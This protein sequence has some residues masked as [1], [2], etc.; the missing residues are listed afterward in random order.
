MLMVDDHP[1][2]LAGLTALVSSDPQLEIV[3]EA[4]DGRSA[5]E[6][7]RR[8]R[9]DIVV[10][11]ISIPE[12]T[13][14]TVMTAL[15]AELPATRVLVLTVHEDRAYVRQMMEAG[16]AGY[17]L[18]RCAAEELTRAIGIVGAGGI[19]LDPAIAGRALGRPE[20]ACGAGAASEVSLSDREADVL[21]LV[22]SGHSNKEIAGTLEISIKTVE[23]YKARAM[24]KLGFRSRVDLVRYAAARGWLA[25]R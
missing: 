24:E 6:A 1:V 22:A 13:G 19:Y 12:L 18:K 23:T 3:G 20:P 5:L 7:A 15:Q 9:P 21:R 10:L 11:D 8:L 14:A 16:A 17:L 25:D 4:R 2:V